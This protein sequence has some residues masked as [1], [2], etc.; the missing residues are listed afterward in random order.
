MGLVEDPSR[1]HQSDVTKRTLHTLRHSNDPAFLYLPLCH[2]LFGLTSGQ[3]VK[4][5]GPML[6]ALRL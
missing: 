3:R 6:R 1:L 4:S 2:M 5:P